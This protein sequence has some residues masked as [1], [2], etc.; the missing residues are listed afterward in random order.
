[1]LAGGG[2]GV[3]VLEKVDRAVAV[4]MG[5]VVLSTCVG[6]GELCVGMSDLR[7]MTRGGGE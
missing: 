1:M 3:E 4:S 7:S 2:R 5:S 6:G